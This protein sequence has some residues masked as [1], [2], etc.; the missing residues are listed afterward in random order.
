MQ[1]KR[2]VFIRVV[3]LVLAPGFCATVSAQNTVQIVHPGPME[4][5]YGATDILIEVPRDAAV[6]RVLVYVDRFT[7]PVCRLT[8][9]PFV[10]KFDAGRMYQ[11]RNI[12]ALAVKRNGEPVGEDTL[13]TL[14]FS[15]PV[16]SVQYVMPVPVVATVPAGSA[17]QLDASALACSYGGKPCD[18]IGAARLSFTEG[19]PLSVELLVD[20]SPSVRRNRAELLKAVESVITAIPAHAEVAIT[21]FSFEYR[22]LGGFT[23]HRAALREQILRLGENQSGTCLLQAIYKSLGVLGMRPGHRMLFVISDGE[24]T[25]DSDIAAGPSGEA[26]FQM[27]PQALQAVMSRARQ[28]SVPLYV[29]RE[30]EIDSGTGSGRSYEGLAR[31]TGGRLFATGGLMGLEAAFQDLVQDV[32]STWVVDVALPADARSGRT[33]RLLLAPPQ[34]SDLQLRYPEYWKPETMQRRRMAQLQSDSPS[35]RFDAAQQLFHDVDPAVLRSLSRAARHEQEEQ[36]RGLELAG[37]VNISAHLLI[38]GDLDDQEKALN[39]IAH[40]FKVEGAPV[41]RLMPALDVYGKADRPKRMVR[42]AAGYA[43]RLESPIRRAAVGGK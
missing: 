1:E 18:V 26:Y 16:R 37:M 10:C 30:K 5:L 15:E 3:V 9:A 19:Q 23:S 21:E 20:V 29:Y 25:C 40:L 14:G 38:H 13:S 36:I 12:R 41:S 32:R 35:A 34:A 43:N 27:Q 4:I 42:R 28:V 33:R 17:P 39:T 6:D 22:R 24:D 2:R 11:G 31:E 8:A 7:R